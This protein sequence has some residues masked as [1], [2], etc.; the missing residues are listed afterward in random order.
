MKEPDWETLVRGKNRL[1]ELNDGTDG[2]ISENGKQKPKAI[3][4]TAAQAIQQLLE[5]EEEQQDGWCAGDRLVVAAARV[6]GAVRTTD[7]Q[8]GS[9]KP[10]LSV[11]QHSYQ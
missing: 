11:E 9:S 3:F 6:G 5:V 7:K 8:D 1:T 2:Q 10:L 4:M